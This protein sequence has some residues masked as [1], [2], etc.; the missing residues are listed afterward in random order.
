M[1]DG[2]FLTKVINC[3]F[4]D[5]QYFNC[6]EI[7]INDNEIDMYDTYIL[8]EDFEEHHHIDSEIFDKIATLINNRD[9]TVDKIREE[10]AKQIRELCSTLLS[11]QTKN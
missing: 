6:K 2:I 11:T 4:T 8:I 9:N 1:F 5:V 7:N 10:F 3:N